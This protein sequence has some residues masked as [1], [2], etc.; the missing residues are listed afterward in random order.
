[1]ANVRE[2]TCKILEMMDQGILDPKKIVEMCL[3]YMSED[4]VKDMARVNELFM[5]D[6][7]DSDEC[8]DDSD[9]EEF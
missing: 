8:Q 6:E 2:A 4:D 3:A 5:D 7:D 1:M 9:D